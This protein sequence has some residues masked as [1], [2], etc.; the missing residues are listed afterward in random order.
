MPGEAAV[1]SGA[2]QEKPPPEGSHAREEPLVT[3]SEAQEE[4]TT[5][6]PLLLSPFDQSRGISLP[7][8]RFLTFEPAICCHFCNQGDRSAAMVAAFVLPLS[9]LGISGLE[10]S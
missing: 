1:T 7:L 4:A 8:S 3:G 9:I 5:P 6:L 10:K 2:G